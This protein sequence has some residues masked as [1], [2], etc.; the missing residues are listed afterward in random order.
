[1]P[2]RIKRLEQ[3]VYQYIKSNAIFDMGS[4][5]PIK[6]LRHAQNLVNALVVDGAT[7]NRN[8]LPTQLLGVGMDWSEEPGSYEV[9]LTIG[10]FIVLQD[11][12][13]LNAALRIRQP[14]GLQATYNDL[15]EQ[16]SLSWD[17]V[18]DASGYRVIRNP[19]AEEVIVLDGDTGFSVDNGVA[20]FID[21]VGDNLEHDYV[22]IALASNGLD[23]SEFTTPVQGKGYSMATVPTGLTASFNDYEE[24]VDLTWNASDNATGYTIRRDGA[25]I[26]SN[27]QSTTYTDTTGDNETYTYTVRANGE[28]AAANSAFSSGVQGRGYSVV[29][30]VLSW[31]QTTPGTLNFTIP[32]DIYSINSVDYFRLIGGGGS[33][34]SGAGGG[35]G[36]LESGSFIGAGGGG[37]GGMR[38]NSGQATDIILVSD[39]PIGQSY[40][41]IVGS[42]G[43]AR[44][45]ASGGTPMSG[46]IFAPIAATNGVT[47]TPGLPGG[48]SQFFRSGDLFM[49]APGGTGGTGT[50]AGGSPSGAGAA[51][52]GGGG[53]PGGNASPTH[54]PGGGGSG[55]AATSSFNTLDGEKG[56]GGAGGNGGGGGMP[57]NNGASG[58]SSGAGGSG[59]FRLDISVEKRI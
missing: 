35:G 21:N 22:V 6:R 25:V 36:G 42:G 26:E 5:T 51:G 50:A 39:L 53:N 27:H 2:A 49:T 7:I 44:A 14:T 38:G 54:S 43:T 34:Q 8:T 41:A 20:T 45:G 3:I 57:A 32:S 33:G 23:H 56:W 16:V 13:H 1:M 4:L 19:G 48:Q 31:K 17:A 11:L 28:V 58:S 37:R 52:G 24:Q 9:A 12:R 10:D 40:S 47:G 55:L 15:E 30:E 29:N 46:N 18:G 59:Y